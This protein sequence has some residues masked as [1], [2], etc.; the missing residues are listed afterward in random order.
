MRK[1]SQSISKG[2]PLPVTVTQ[3]VHHDHSD[4]N[5][6]FSFALSRLK[7]SVNLELLYLAESAKITISANRIQVAR[8]G[9]KKALAESP[10]RIIFSTRRT[11]LLPPSTHN[12]YPICL[13]V[14][15]PL[16]RVPLHCN[17]QILVSITAISPPP[18][19][20]QPTL[21]TI[22]HPWHISRG[23]TTITTKLTSRMAPVPA[24]FPI[25]QL[26]VAQIFCRTMVAWSR[27]TALESCV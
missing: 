14:G 16:I 18:T 6:R 19:P 27:P 13:C 21:L 20:S 12:R 2:S 11:H 25:Q 8:G 17:V 5:W 10:S 23:H 24:Q 4:V 1:Q 3:L 15:V 9:S 7:Y 22:Q 26:T